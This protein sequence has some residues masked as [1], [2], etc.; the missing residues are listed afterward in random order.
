METEAAAAR[1]TVTSCLVCRSTRLHYLFSVEGHRIVRCED[2][3]LILTNP[4]PPGD[5]IGRLHGEDPAPGP[6]HLAALRD[7]SA[8]L[9]L[10]LLQRYGLPPNARLLQLG[11]GEGHFLAR[12]LARGLDVTG[13]DSSAAAC[14]AARAR[15]GPAG[16]VRQGELA[17]PGWGDG[18]FDACVLSGVLDQARDP[19]ALLEAVHR[20][21]KPG[22]VLFV[23]TP[24]LDSW[25][26]RVLRPR[27]GKFRPDRL[28]YFKSATLQTLLI[29]GDFG[30]LIHRPDSSGMIVLARKQAPPA[31]RKLSLIIPVYNEAPTFETAFSRLLAKQVEGL[32]IEL[33]V[34]ESFSTDGTRDL[35][36]R[37]EGHPRVK[38]LWEDAPRGKGHAVRAGLEVITGDYVLIQ[39][40]DLEYDLEDYEALLEPLVLG[41]AAFV[42]GARHGGSAWKMRQFTGQPLL[43]MILNAAHWFFTWLVNVLYGARLRDPFTMYKVFR[44]DCLYGLRFHCNRFDFD[45][46][47]VIKMLRK[48]YVPLEIPVNYRSRSFHEGKKVSFFRDPLTWLRVL[49]VCRL[50]TIDPLAEIE[51]VRAAGIP[52]VS[53]PSS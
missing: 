46:E 9:H 44:R 49:A 8:D 17:G 40:A 11:C 3:S 14:L 29:Q 48:G 50:E 4:Q 41:R 36:R 30:G 1:L 23:A 34:V 21:L 35:V 19:R 37:Y 31:R 16:V 10:D 24:T 18:E 12:A 45:F 22:G 7:T 5:E 52:G 15:V 20:A 42:L 28:W 13:V 43:T 53:S 47:L 25:R 39:D 27:W 38:I 32:D 26:A 2:C 51:R 6:P 33:V